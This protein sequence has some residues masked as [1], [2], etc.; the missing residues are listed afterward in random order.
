ME[1]TLLLLVAIAV[2]GCGGAQM[3]AEHQASNA[4]AADLQKAIDNCNKLH[5]PAK[6]AVPL[7]RC[8]NEADMRWQLDRARHVGGQSLD[9]VQSIHAQM[10]VIAEKH[11]LKKITPNEFTAEY[12][13]LKA[14]MADRINSESQAVYSANQQNQ[15]AASARA[16]AAGA[17]IMS[18]PPTTTC[19]R[20]GNTMTCR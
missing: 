20:F 6:L 5:G 2:S 12:G 17:A 11:D 16:I 9:F 19:T 15:Q 13:R 1:K 10:I 8:W 14:Q 18:G 4:A 7:V 3:A